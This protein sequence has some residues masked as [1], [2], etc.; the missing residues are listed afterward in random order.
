MAQKSK[1]NN[2]IPKITRMAQ[3]IAPGGAFFF[4]LSFLAG[5]IFAMPDLPTP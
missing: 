1:D 3:G 4:A 2:T 5:L